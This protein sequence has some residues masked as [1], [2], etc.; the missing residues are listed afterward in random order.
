MEAIAGLIRPESGQIRSTTATYSGRC[1]A[2]QA[3]L[4]RSGR[5]PQAAISIIPWQPDLRAHTEAKRRFGLQDFRATKDNA[6]KLVEAFDIRPPFP[7]QP[8]RK[9]SG[10]NQQKVVVAREFDR[11][12]DLLICAQ[13]TRGVDIGA[14]E[15]IHLQVVAQRDRGA[16]VL[17][18][19]AELDEILSLSDRIAVMYNGKIVAVMPVEEADEHKLGFLMLGGR[20]EDY[21]AGGGNSVA[22]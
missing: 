18:V 22:G 1:S 19:S 13:P 6:A 12:P 8:A 21:Q 11:N 20:L 3:G 15:F 7:H 2:S 10:G 14:I 16:A 4:I 5:P 9:L 17:L